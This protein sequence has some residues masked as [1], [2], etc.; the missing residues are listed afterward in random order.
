MV[1]RCYFGHRCSPWTPAR[2]LHPF[3]RYFHCTMRDDLG[4]AQVEEL[5]QRWI[6]FH[7]ES[8][9][10]PLADAFLVCSELPNRILNVP[11]QNDIL[12]CPEGITEEQVQDAWIGDLRLKKVMEQ[13]KDSI[14]T[15]N[16]T[17]R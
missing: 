10:L 8:E 7:F 4:E 3:G 12:L 1:N 5:S 11:I 14:G 9:M 16:A 15:H 13:L 17:V 6:R 2:D